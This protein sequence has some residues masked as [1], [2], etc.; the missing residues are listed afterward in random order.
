MKNLSLLALG[1]SLI[2]PNAM[3]F[4]D[5]HEGE[6][7]ETPLQEEMSSMNKAWKSIRRAAKDPAEFA[8]AAEMVGT[9]IEHAKN[10]IDMDPILLAEQEGE[11][12]KE[13]FM[14][15]YQEGMQETVVLLEELKAAFEVADQAAVVAT[16]D[17]INDARKKGHRSYKPKD[18]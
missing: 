8:H 18:D 15:G 17:K 11:E 16:M 4:A 7:E 12:A 1:L 5:H 2:A 6:H 3:V 13:K 9:M 10:S 14:H